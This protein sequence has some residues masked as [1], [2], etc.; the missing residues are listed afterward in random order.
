MGQQEKQIKAD[1]FRAYQD[2]LK[3]RRQAALEIRRSRNAGRSYN[4]RPMTFADLPGGGIP[5]GPRRELRP[6]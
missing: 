4:R 6:L 2:R 3:Y 1:K 5:A